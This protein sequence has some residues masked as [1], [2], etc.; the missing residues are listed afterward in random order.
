[1]TTARPYR[2]AMT[3]PAAISELRLDVSRGLLSRDLVESFVAVLTERQ[4]DERHPL[5]GDAFTSLS[6]A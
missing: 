5:V 4:R 2:K 1:M 6:V 3:Q